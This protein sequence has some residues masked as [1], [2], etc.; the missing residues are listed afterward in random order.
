[1]KRFPLI[2]LSCSFLCMSAAAITLHLDMTPELAGKDAVTMKQLSPTTMRFTIWISTKNDPKSSPR[3]PFVRGGTLVIHDETGKVA[4]CAVEPKK[5]EG[6][7]LYTFELNNKHARASRFI[8]TEGFVDGQV[9]G[10][11]VFSYRFID[12]LDPNHQT[13]ELLRHI[14][15]PDFS[16]IKIPNTLAPK[17]PEKEREKTKQR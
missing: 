2:A 15:E 7:L 3:R 6:G 16:R 1:M 14:S 9:G 11:K 13:K 17:T 4:R 12:F 8:L 10:G 5:K